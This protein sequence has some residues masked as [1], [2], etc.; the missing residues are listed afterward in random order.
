M[1]KILIDNNQNSYKANLH[2]H[3]T[4]SDGR[5][6]PEEVKEEYKKHGY[7]VVAYTD[8][9]VLIPHGEL[10]DDTF[11][12]LNG[13]EAEILSRWEPFPKSPRCCHICYI[14]LEEDNLTQPLWHREKYLFANAV[15]YKDK[16]KFDES[17]PDFERHYTPECITHMMREGR[18]K[19]FFVTYNHPAWSMEDY[20]DYIRYDGMHAMEM[21]NYGC[22]VEGYPEY[23]ARVYDDMLRSGKRIYCI[24][25]DDNHNQLKDSFGGFT[26]IKA[27]KLEYRAITRS[28]E[29]GN[30]YASQGPEICELSYEDGKVHVTS[31]PA[32]RIF[33]IF[34][35]QRGGYAA[36]EPGSSITE[37]TFRLV[38]DEKYFRITVVDAAGN[39]ADSNAYFLDELTK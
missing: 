7:S 2:C 25:A 18:E 16:V 35:M 39:K 30:F 17:E 23:N 6:T 34:G 4:V 38:G 9:D 19:G 15:N 36:A 24:D 3:T 12:P 26:V 33:C 13:F 28:L 27:D 31:S 5:W 11:L 22:V 14:A 8:H 1:K 10:K 29:S 32:S 37:A 21:C 20:S